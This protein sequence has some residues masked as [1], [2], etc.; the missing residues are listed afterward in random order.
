MR[1]IDFEDEKHLDLLKSLNKNLIIC[2]MED[3]A[4]N[5]YLAISLKVNEFHGKII[6]LTDT[7]QKNRQLKLAGADVIFDLYDESAKEF[8]EQLDLI[9]EKS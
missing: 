3:E 1:L 2:S 8:I 7:K 9:G 4:I 5:H 6:A